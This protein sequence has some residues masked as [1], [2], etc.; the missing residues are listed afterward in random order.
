MLTVVTLRI[1]VAFVFLALLTGSC[2]YGN[3]TEPPP[4]IQAALKYEGQPIASIQFAP[5]DQPLSTTELLARLPFT[6]GVPFRE[7]ELREAIQNLY[8]T[9][10]FSD[11]A[12]DAAQA[13]HGVALRFLTKPAYF[14]GRV[15]V[16]GVKEPP[17]GGQLASATKLQLGAPYSDSDKTSALHSLQNLLRQN[18]FH[19]AVIHSHT[20]LDPTNEEANITFSVTTGARARFSQPVITGNPERSAESIVRATHWKRLYGLLGWQEETEARLQG[21][22][23]NVRHLYVRQG[24]LRSKV[25]LTKLDYNAESNTVK[26]TIDIEAGPR[27]NVRSSGTRLSAS[28][29][30]Q[31]VPVFQEHSVDRDLLIEGQQNIEEYLVSEGYF[32]ADVSYSVKGRANAQEQVITYQIHSGPRHKFTHL[33]ITGNRYFD[34]E[35]IRERL[36]VQPAEFPRFPYGRFGRAYVQQDVEAI[37]RLYAANGFLSAKVNVRTEDNY[38]GAKNHL[39]EFIDIVEGPQ[40]FVAHLSITGVSADDL[41]VLNSMLACL[42][43]QPFSETNV[44]IDRDNFLNYYYSQGYLNASFDYSVA[45]QNGQ[46]NQVNVTYRIT[47]GARKYVRNVLISG[48]DTTRAKLVLDRLELRKGEPLSLAEETDSQRRLYDLGIFARVNTALQNPDGDEDRKNVL[49]DLDEARHYSLNLGVGAQIAR[50]GGSVTTLDNPAGSTG[51]APRFSFGISRLNFLGRAQTLGL[52]T[53]VSTIE[54]RAVVTYFIPQ[55]ISH[56]NLNF[57]ITGLF[58]N[59]NDIRTFTA[60][61]REASIQLGQRLSRAYTVQYRLVFRRVSQSNLKID[62]LLVPLLSQPERVG[63]AEVSLIQDKRDDPVDPHH[64]IY[65]TFD[66]SYAPAFLASQTEFAR[67]LLKNATY[68]PL[69]RGLVFA[70]STQFGLITRTGGRP[71]I[72]LPERLYSGGSTS[73]RAFPDFQAG[74][75]DLVTGFPIGGNV[76]FVNNLELRFPLY[77]D[78]LG[79]VLFHDAGNVYSTLGSFS[80]RFRQRNLQDFNY[81]VQSAGVGIRYRTPIGPIRVDLS[82]SPDAPR[83]YGLKG[84]EQDLIN[85]TAPSQVQKINAFQFHFSLG[86]AF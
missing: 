64:G 59:S 84:N 9:G 1:F 11:L 67:A 66:V 8:R 18:G 43:G 27:I 40:T 54:Q 15:V 76:L 22:V 34:L 6:T 36:Y 5:A 52:Q 49:Y 73:L 26:P 37:R 14:V 3:E 56:E 63:E 30:R 2:S 32:E 10:R 68:Y 85:G 33:G 47:A 28:R 41:P 12:V 75:R 46:P 17:N 70:R 48:L 86:Q 45:P 29:L 44:S 79:G 24:R 53:S 35:T 78:N 20:A 51:F 39:A 42:A 60:R 77:G 19:G 13:E 71:S 80:L 55:F 72:P 65:T 81:M 38:R 69:R 31:L 83:F 4:L 25:S 62:P 61:R 16:A 7:H 50:I 23:D 21:G 74:P 58:N 82:F 57:A